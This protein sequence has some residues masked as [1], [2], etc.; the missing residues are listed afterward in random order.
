MLIYTILIAS[1]KVFLTGLLIVPTLTCIVF[2]PIGF[3]HSIV[4]IVQ[5]KIHTI[6]CCKYC[7]NSSLSCF[8]LFFSNGYFILFLIDHWEMPNTKYDLNCISF[9]LDLFISVSCW[10]RCMWSSLCWL[11][12]GHWQCCSGQTQ[13]LLLWGCP[14]SREFVINKCLKIIDWQF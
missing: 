6:V 8:M 3:F 5:C 7:F 9:Y 13:V 14:S 2:F 1:S 10:N 11:L 12:G 4:H